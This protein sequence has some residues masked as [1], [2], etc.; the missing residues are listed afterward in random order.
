MADTSLCP[1]LYFVLDEAIFSG[2]L[3]RNG[4]ALR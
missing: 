2:R 3:N 1:V 4:D